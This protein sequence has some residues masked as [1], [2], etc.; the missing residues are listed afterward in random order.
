M[1]EK[2]IA[3]VAD[4]VVSA[5]T[6]LAP[7][8]W[9]AMVREKHTEGLLDIIVTV[10]LFGVL[11][12]AGKVLWPLT[13]MKEAPSTANGYYAYERVPDDTKD[14]KA[15]KTELATGFTVTLPAILGIGFI[16]AVIVIRLG[17]LELLH[18]EYFAVEKIIEAAK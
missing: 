10:G 12:L 18:P 7:G 16:V 6:Q 3:D 1:T 8:V 15:R 9:D 14:P 13:R 4:K 5:F 17:I 2:T 11:C